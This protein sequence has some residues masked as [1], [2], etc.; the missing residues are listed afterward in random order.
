[1]KRLEKHQS[2]QRLQ[3]LRDLWNEYDPISVYRHGWPDDWPRDEY[4]SYLRRTLRFLEQ[5]AREREVI[6]YLRKVV[7]DGMGLQFD[8]TEAMIFARRLKAWFKDNWDDTYG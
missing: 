7:A 6:H 3:E 2:Q 1:M 5:D 8:E 4:N